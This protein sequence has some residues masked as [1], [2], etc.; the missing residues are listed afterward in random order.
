MCISFIY[1]TYIAGGKE[2]AKAPIPELKPTNQIQKCKPKIQFIMPFD[3]PD[4]QSLVSAM[5]I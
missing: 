2:G 5:Y 4:E 3:F 1:D